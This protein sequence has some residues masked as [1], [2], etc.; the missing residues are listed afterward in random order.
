MRKYLLAFTALVAFQS[1]FSQ[2]E[3][4]KRIYHQFDSLKKVLPTVNG[5]GKVDCLNALA[6]TATDLPLGSWKAEADTARPYATQA[7]N[8]AK[9]IAYK[10]G[11][12]DSYVNLETLDCMMFGTYAQQ[13]RRFDDL[14]FNSARQNAKMA[15]AIGEELADHDMLGETYFVL[16]WLLSET[17]NTGNRHQYIAANLDYGKKAIEYYSKTDNKDRLK[18]SY[19]EYSFL[20]QQNNDFEI[21]TNCVEKAIQL[22]LEMGDTAQA[23]YD[24]RHILRINICTGDFEKGLENSKKEIQ[25]AETLPTDNKGYNI[26][27]GGALMVMSIIYNTAGDY[28]TAKELLNKSFKYYPQKI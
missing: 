26:E 23:A 19:I 8:E 4:G 21:A 3:Y 6:R 20:A 14:T 1:L 10:K 13:Q 9:R 2:D 18:Q 27:F 11:L 22:S 15:I 17:R 16:S 12:G 24:Y 7:N 25:L 28:E 5:P